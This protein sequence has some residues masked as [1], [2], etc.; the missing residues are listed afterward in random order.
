MREEPEPSSVPDREAEEVP[1]W[2]PEHSPGSVNAVVYRRGRLPGLWI[3]TRGAWRRGWVLMRQDY[4]GPGG[5][6]RRYAYHVEITLPNDDDGVLSTQNLA[7]W[8]GQDAVRV[9][10]PPLPPADGS[11]PTDEPWRT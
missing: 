10:R 11:R 9:L 2:R 1:P 4:P 5:R 7:V 3:Y 8:W 6:G